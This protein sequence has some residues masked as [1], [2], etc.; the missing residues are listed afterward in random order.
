MSLK[1]LG[2]ALAI[3]GLAGA[4]ARAGEP[5]SAWQRN[6]QAAARL[7]AAVTAVGDSERLPVGLELDLQPG[8]DTYWRSPGDSGIPV[9]V[10]WSASRNVASAE[11]AWPA[12]RRFTL[13]GLETFG[14]SGQVVFPVTVTP[15]RRGEAVA[16][17][18]AVDYLVCEK[19]C[20]P[21][22]ADLAL[23]LPAGAGGPSAFVQLIDRW[24]ARV[25]GDG[26][27][28]G[29]AV[30]GVAPGAGSTLEVTARADV[31]FTAPDLIVE[32]PV[33]LHFAA[34][35][36]AL[37]DG[38][39]AARLSLAVGRDDGAPALE[40]AK[41]TLTLVDGARALERQ[42]T[43]GQALP[44]AAPMPAPAPAA[45]GGAGLLAMLLLGL[46]GGLILNLMP[47]VLPVLS[48]KLLGVVG[49]GGS[50]RRAVRA[51]FLAS[52]A[53]VLASFLVLAAVLVGLREGGVA[54]GWGIQFQQPLFLVA[55]VLVVTLFACNLFG[56][57]EIP[58]PG[59]VGDLAVAA[60]GEGGR[61]G[62]VGNF[63]AG[64]LATLLA[65]PCSA[66]FLGTAIGF[67]LAGSAGE[68]AAIFAAIGV[69]LALPYL[70][71]AA[72]P[73]LATR[74]PRPGR[75]MIG[76]RWALGLLLAG[77]AIWLLS[78]LA[79]QVGARP[80][81]VVGG[82]MVGL[83]ALLSARGVLPARLRLAVPASFLVLAVAA[84]LVPGRLGERSALPARAEGF[85]QP[86]AP[87]RIAVLVGEGK[88]VFID[89]TAD[90]CITCQVN[91][92]LVLDSDAIRRRLSG[93]G[94][95][96]MKADWT[97]PSD[98]IV[99]YLASFGRYGI[100]FNAVYGPQARDGIALPELLSREAVLDGV[101]RAGG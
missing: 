89:V 12:P 1:R 43:P 65:T 55:M 59:W 39:R 35:K 50:E 45:A 15:S 49:H 70:L 20:V 21:R 77:T 90:W 29:L 101:R 73:G 5:A 42:V 22:H 48:L 91:Q 27:G 11:M 14:Y 71:I 7:V 40:A 17:R 52:A 84:F 33:G 10:D 95:V 92:R 96:A 83:A 30:T 100:P 81:L 87:E 67:A 60:P 3:A 34:P 75:W 6:D 19:I 85:W 66:P 68:I 63:L 54:I 8:W 47:C 98:A 69:G 32:G 38:G 78:V 53:G 82:L 41:L 36:V 46:L 76:L 37:S 23:D 86:F 62:L 26:A 93:E 80:A 28:Q 18:V 61:H 74:L 44:G 57:F 25:P 56:W 72:F 4:V 99:R 24:R 16:L 97:L 79:G 58:L 2:L 9:T 64:A 31:P 13:L 88:L 51:A 94:I